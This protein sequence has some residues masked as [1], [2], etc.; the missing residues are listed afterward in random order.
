[1]TLY[2]GARNTLY[3]LFAIIGPFGAFQ[4]LKSSSQ[5][6]QKHQT[7][8]SEIMVLRF[9]FLSVLSLCLVRHFQ[10]NI[11]MTHWH[12]A[13]VAT[14]IVLSLNILP[15]YCSQKAVTFVGHNTVAMSFALMPMVIFVGQLTLLKHYQMEL[16]IMA[17][18]LFIITLLAK[19]YPLTFSNSILR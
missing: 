6:I 16:L 7:Q 13:I 19:R 3:T 11:I 8:T 14:F 15:I 4:V 17:C 2:I 1:M 18:L 9:L 5:Y 12:I 10:F